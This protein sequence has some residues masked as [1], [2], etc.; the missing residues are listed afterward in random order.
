MQY[1]LPYTPANKGYSIQMS[2]NVSPTRSINV[3]STYYPRFQNLPPSISRISSGPVVQFDKNHIQ[4]MVSPHAH[5]FVA[6]QK[7]RLTNRVYT[8][9]QP[10]VPTVDLKGH[11]IEE[12][13]AAANVSVEVIQQAIYQK[14]KKLE[15]EF[16]ANYTRTSSTR[17]P[18]TL[19]TTISTTSTTRRPSTKLLQKKPSKKYQLSNP[20][21]HKVMNAP[22]EYYPVGYDKNFDDNFT[23]RVD[24]PHTSFH[25]GD[26]KH[27]PGLY[28][29]EELGCM[30][31]HV[32][33]LTDNGLIMKSF[34]CP[35]STRFDQTIL[36][37]NWW[38]YV[39]CSNSRSLYDSNLPV[40]KSYQLMK[41]L[42]FFSKYKKQ[43]NETSTDLDMDA[44]QNSVNIDDHK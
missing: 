43:G 23:A 2:H 36:K 26:Q 38:F 42:S 22:K 12:L 3:P 8:E 32:C 40:S 30:V 41:A 33:A 39:D 31:F 4:S 20:S 29:D 25:C 17:Q 6:P 7:T 19:S 44:L 18:T 15:E 24:L 13:A 5:S 34:L 14:Q 21:G 10:T 1:E 27:F 16:W 28:A 35:E 37:C 11:T 9:E